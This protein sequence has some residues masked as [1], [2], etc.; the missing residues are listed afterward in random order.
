MNAE[1]YRLCTCDHLSSAKKSRVTVTSPAHTE[2]TNEAR[3]YILF[4]PET[5]FCTEPAETARILRMRLN[6]QGMQNF[7]HWNVLMKKQQP[8]KE[9]ALVD[10]ERKKKD[11][12]AAQRKASKE[13]KGLPKISPNNQHPN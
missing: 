5:L 6:W 2:R 11:W 7:T 8:W 12:R 4:F 3:K 9:K 1:R 13:S 10:F